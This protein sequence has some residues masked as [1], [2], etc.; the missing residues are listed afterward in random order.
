[1]Q[2]VEQRLAQPVGGRPDRLRL[3]RG[4][5]AAAQPS[6]DDAHQRRPPRAAGGGGAF[7]AARAPLGRCD[8]D[9]RGGACVCASRRAG[10]RGGAAGASCCPIGPEKSAP[11]MAMTRSPSWSRKVRVFTSSICSWREVGELER[12]ERHADQAVDLEAEVTEHVLDLA[13]LA[14]PHREGEPD[15]AALRAIERGLDRAVADA[16]DGDAGA[17]RVELILPQRGRARARGNGAANR[18]PAARARAQARRR[19]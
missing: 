13:V 10:G 11:A 12:A 15:I 14:L 17:Q 19:W 8:R 16:V 9:R 3:R 1:M 7:P 18:S 6:A 5:R 4:E 2:D